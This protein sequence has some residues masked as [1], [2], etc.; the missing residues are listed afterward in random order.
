MAGREADISI[1]HSYFSHKDFVSNH[2]GDIDA[3]L[4]ASQE[5]I[6]SLGAVQQLSDLSHASF[7]GIGRIVQMI[8]WLSN[9]GLHLAPENFTVNVQSGVVQRKL[10]EEGI[11][12]AVMPK[13]DL[14]DHTIKAVLPNQFSISVPIWLSAHRQ[15]LA[16]RRVKFVYDILAEELRHHFRSRSS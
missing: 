7:I 4:C 1:R 2:V 12:I 16:S 5:Y 13:S 9:Y 14:P 15:V 8:E 3:Y 6:K 10:V 11:G